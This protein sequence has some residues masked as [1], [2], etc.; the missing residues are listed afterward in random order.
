MGMA[1]II[2]F[3]RALPELVK[4]MGEVVNALRQM[5]QDAIDRELEKIRNEVDSNI[6]KLTAAKTDEERKKILLDLNRAIGR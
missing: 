1:E 3:I 6:Q 2:A 5:K 4:V